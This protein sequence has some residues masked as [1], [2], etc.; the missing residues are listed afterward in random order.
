MPEKT[1]E[2][3]LDRMTPELETWQSTCRGAELVLKGINRNY[4]PDVKIGALLLRGACQIQV[5]KD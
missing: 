5:K 1:E 3:L 4:D 2:V